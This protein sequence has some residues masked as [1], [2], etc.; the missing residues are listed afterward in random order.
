MNVSGKALT[1]NATIS[2]LTPNLLKEFQKLLTKDDTV[3]VASFGEKVIAALIDAGV[4]KG[5]ASSK[6]PDYLREKDR[7]FYWL[8]PAES[9]PNVL[10]EL[11]ME[12]TL[13]VWDGAKFV[14]GPLVEKEQAIAISTK[15]PLC[16]N[17]T[18]GR[19]AALDVSAFTPGDVLGILVLPEGEA[20]LIKLDHRENHPCHIEHEVEPCHSHL[21]L[22]TN[23]V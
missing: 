8:K 7:G 21:S 19:P 14:E 11:Q 18:V 15:H 1:Q 4:I 16:G 9:S 6:Q 5:T 23:L 12:A 10:P 20:A 22:E 13:Q 17:G 2:F 3:L